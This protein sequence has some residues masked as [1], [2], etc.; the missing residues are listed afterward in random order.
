MTNKQKQVVATLNLENTNVFK[1]VVG[2]WKHG[3]HY[4]VFKNGSVW[5]ECPP[6][7]YH[8]Y[9]FTKKF[10]FADICERHCNAHR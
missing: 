5:V 8:E 10:K 2:A 1:G 6:D 7:K 3:N 4:K 9:A